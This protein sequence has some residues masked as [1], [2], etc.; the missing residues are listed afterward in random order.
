ME[1]KVNLFIPS[2]TVLS[3]SAYAGVSPNPESIYTAFPTVCLN[4]ETQQ[5]IVVEVHLSFCAGKIGTNLT[6]I[7]VSFLL[8]LKGK[9]SSCILGLN[10]LLDIMH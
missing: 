7:F 2:V 3:I 10:N 9:N 6:P 4:L 1:E 5:K 8:L